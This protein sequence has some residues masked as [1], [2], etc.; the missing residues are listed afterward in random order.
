MKYGCRPKECQNENISLYMSVL[1]S[2]RAKFPQ[3]PYNFQHPSAANTRHLALK[4]RLAYS[5][6]VM[7]NIYVGTACKAGRNLSLCAPERFLIKTISIICATRHKTN[8]DWANKWQRV[9]QCR[10]Y[11]G[12]RRC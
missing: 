4:I 11:K 9:S 8:E 6:T 2:K 3:P 10:R 7:K 1:L 5:I 12:V